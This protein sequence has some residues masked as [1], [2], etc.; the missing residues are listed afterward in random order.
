MEPG[1]LRGLARG[2]EGF[3]MP[4]L[5]LH[6]DVLVFSD[7]ARLAAGV[8]DDAGFPKA[9]CVTSGLARLL[10]DLFFD[11]TRAATPSLEEIRCYGTEQ[12]AGPDHPAVPLDVEG[13]ERFVATQRGFELGTS[14]Q[15]LGTIGTEVFE[16]D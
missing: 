7:S 6:N 8:V 16:D 1:G 5:N 9:R 14:E 3:A 13:L 10:E 11:P 15:P 2:E 12:S 4:F